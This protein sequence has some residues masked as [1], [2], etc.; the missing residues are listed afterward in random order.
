[1]QFQHHQTLGKLA[2]QKACEFL[3]TQGYQIVVCN[4]T[5]AKVGEIDI[6]AF[7][8]DGL[9][10]VE[11]KARTRSNFGHAIEQVTP[12]KQKKM[13]YTMLYF[14]QDEQYQAYKN[15]SIRFDV[16]GFDGETMSWIQ[17]AFLAES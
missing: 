7:G 4:Y 15:A 6:I 16:I 5:L 9:V 1:M 12:A 13:I 3:Q 2:E 14:L 10:A 17:G 8:Q 11:V